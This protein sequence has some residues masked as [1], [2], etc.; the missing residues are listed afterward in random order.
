VTLTADPRVA[1]GEHRCRALQR[2]GRRGQRTTRQR[3]TT[4]GREQ[5]SGLF[6]ITGHYSQFGSQIAPGAT[7]VRVCRLNH[8]QRGGR[9]RGAARRQRHFQ[10]RVPGE[11]MP[12]P[13]LPRQ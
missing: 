10:D 12:E 11:R 3:G 1:R 5:L 9:Q 6:A 2:I 7:R 4:G 13:E 8:R